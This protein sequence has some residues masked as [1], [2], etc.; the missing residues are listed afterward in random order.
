M[1][2][3]IQNT[4]AYLGNNR[5]V[6][7]TYF[8][9]RIIIDTRN[10]QNYSIITHGFYEKG[11]AWAIEKYLKPGDTMI[12]V[13]ANIGFFTLLGNHIVGPKGKVY[14][15]EPNP[16]IFELMKSSVHIN[17]FR[18][19]SVRLNMAAFNEPGTL[20][21]TWS[22]AKHGGGRLRTHDKIKL[23]EKSVEV[24]TE[25]LD[26]LVNTEDLP[27]NL[28]K[29]DTEGS[30]LYALQGAQEI[31]AKSPNCV[32]ITEWNPNFLR[33]RGSSVT[34][35][36]EFISKRFNI[37]ER[38]VKVGEVLQLKPDQLLGINHCNLILRN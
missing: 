5:A 30:E 22:A 12:D 19:R 11:V 36:V 2:N 24:K 37:I 28:I 21:L 13:G 9:R 3:Q 8:G 4:Y 10:I 17:A 25:K 31:L 6:T 27:V 26:T 33:G 32:I 29:I 34:E 14:S 16:D 35:A 20:E 23:D 18:P 7:M 38:I 1:K 15:L